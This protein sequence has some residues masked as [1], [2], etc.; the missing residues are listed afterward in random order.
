MTENLNA[1][2]S[3]GATPT[4]PSGGAQGDQVSVDRAE[5]ERLQSL[6]QRHERL[7]A[8]ARALGLSEEEYLATLEE[9]GAGN[10]D[11][12]KADPPAAPSRNNGGAPPANA[13]GDGQTSETVRRLLDRA[14]A[15][16]DAAYLNAQHVE[17][18]IDESMKPEAERSKHP[19]QKLDELIRS[20]AW[21]TAIGR[22]AGE[23]EFGGNVYKAAAHLIDSKEMAKAAVERSKQAADGRAASA[24][25]AAGPGGSPPKPVP[26]PAKGDPA[27][28]LADMIAPKTVKG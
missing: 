17:F 16:G 23:P 12:F 8:N 11:D 22:L 9:A 24:V 7:F 14:N 3:G 6:N 4:P 2:G 10:L 15:V 1:G 28:E 5:L 25:T 21:G 13:G 20:R 26:P 19:R 27:K 18:R